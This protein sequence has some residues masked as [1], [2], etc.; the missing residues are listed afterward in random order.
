M[1]LFIATIEDDDIRSKL[2]TIYE[3]YSG[4]MYRKAYSVLENKSDAEDAVSEAFIRLYKNVHVIRVPESRETKS[5]AII[6]AEHCAI[7][8]YRKRKRLNETELDESILVT[9]V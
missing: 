5:L 7:D 9:P 2:E 4:A 3:K 8:I 1:L 6:I